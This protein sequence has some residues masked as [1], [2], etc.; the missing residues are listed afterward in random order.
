MQVVLQWTGGW[1][2]DSVGELNRCG[3]GAGRGFLM[4]DPL[5]TQQPQGQEQQQQQVQQQ[6]PANTGAA[7][8]PTCSGVPVM[9]MR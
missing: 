9:S 7:A 1:V 5:S 8:G 4:P 6:A 2:V 3:W